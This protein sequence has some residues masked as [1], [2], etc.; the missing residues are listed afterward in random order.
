VQGFI[1][2]GSMLIS[3]SSPVKVCAIC[4]RSLLTGERATRFSPEGDGEYVDVCPLCAELALEHG[5]I[6]EGSPSTPTLRGPKRRRRLTLG[7]LFEPRRNEAE[8]IAAEPLLRRLSPPEAAIVEAADL[9]NGSPF[10]R[11]VAGIARSL[12]EPQASIMRLSGVNR[13]AVITV[14]WDIAW[15]QYRVTYDSVQPVRLAERGDE[16]EDLDVAFRR[17]NAHL[18]GEGRVVP[19]VALA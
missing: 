2:L 15:Y 13:E 3:T 6:R 9:F 14:A 18:D 10:R 19:E 12:G 8:T 4:E 5:W 11:T 17:W 7:S 16:L 1:V